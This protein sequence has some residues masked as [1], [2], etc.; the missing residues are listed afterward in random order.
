MTVLMKYS[1]IDNY[2]AEELIVAK[3][4]DMVWADYILQ[5]HSNYSKHVCITEAIRW[6]V[7]SKQKIRSITKSVPQLTCFQFNFQVFLLLVFHFHTLHYFGMQFIAR[8]LSTLLDQIDCGGWVVFGWAEPITVGTEHS[9]KFLYSMLI[10]LVVVWFGV[11]P[12][13]AWHWYLLCLLA[14]RS[15]FCRFS[16][17]QFF[18]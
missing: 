10:K 13:V 5:S 12:K 2:R 16:C 4:V 7:N 18:W 11:A 9:I 1:R 15:F 14:L 8:L 3:W 17:S 6:T